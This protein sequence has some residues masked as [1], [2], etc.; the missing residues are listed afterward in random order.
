MIS[1]NVLFFQIC[2]HGNTVRFHFLNMKRASSQGFSQVTQ[3]TLYAEVFSNTGNLGVAT[4]YHLPFLFSPSSVFVFYFSLLSNPILLLSNIN[5][6]FN[7]LHG[8]SVTTKGDLGSNLAFQ[9]LSAL[10]Y[11]VEAISVFL[12]A[13]QVFFEN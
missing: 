12:C 13:S 5:V 10:N 7:L 6:L 2:C 1:Q 11:F 8:F 9:Y 4:M 3:P